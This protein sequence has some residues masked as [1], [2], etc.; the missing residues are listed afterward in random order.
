MRRPIFLLFLS[1]L[2]AVPL[3]ACQPAAPATPT[4]A[5]TP[6]TKTLTDMAGQTVTIPLPIL[7]FASPSPADITYFSVLGVADKLVATDARIPTPDFAIT[8]KKIAPSTLSIAYPFSGSDVN[9]EELLKAKP[10]FTFMPMG[11]KRIATIQAAGIPVIQTAPNL[12]V[13]QISH[14]VTFYGDVFGGDAVQNAKNVTD[15]YAAQKS[16][17][18]SKIGAMPAGQ[19][20]KIILM[21][22]HGGGVFIVFGR[23][24]WQDDAITLVG[25]INE[26]ASEIDGKKSDVT[27]EQ[28]LKWDPDVIILSDVNQTTAKPV[29][30]MAGWDQLTAVK[31]QRMYI[32][33]TGIYG[34]TSQVVEAFLEVQWLAKTFYPNQFPDLDLNKETKH[35][36]VDFYHYNVSD[37]EVEDILKATG[38]FHGA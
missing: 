18:T 22:Y 21:Q 1:L 2:L 29:F 37:A 19:K 23:N 4:A 17:I 16:L 15:Y 10:Q 7:R 31:N 14:L 13:D 38:V 25:G 9:M 26:A 6:S 8:F 20:S 5:P 32:N 36:L 24:T 27:M 34:F 30:A 11:D 28:L 3:A 33:P 12:T 35:V